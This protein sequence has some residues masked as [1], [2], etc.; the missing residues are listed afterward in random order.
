M[1][2][3]VR[4][5]ASIREALG[6]DSEVLE[7]EALDAGSLLLQLRARSSV[8]ASALAQGRPVRM[9]VDQVMARGD[10]P[11]REGAEVGFFPPVTGG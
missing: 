2:V 10:T 7:T 6:V 8:H 11:L 3:Q 4:Y 9:S 1:K 5:F